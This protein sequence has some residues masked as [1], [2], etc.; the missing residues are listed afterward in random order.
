MSVRA[1]VTGGSGFIG[2][3]LVALF[4]E[5]GIPVVSL[6]ARPPRNSA[7]KTVWKALDI[8]DRP[9]LEGAIVDFDPTHVVH[10][11]ARTDLRE[12]T[13]IDGYRSNVLGVAN[14]IETL[15]GCATLEH[16]VFASSMLVCRNGYSPVSDTDYC[17][18]TLYGSSKVEG[19]RLIRGTGKTLPWTI[20]RPTSIWGPWFGEPY[21]NFFETVLAR[22]YF[23]PRGHAV[24]KALGF[25]GNTILQITG[26]LFADLERVRGRTFYLCD[27]PAYSVEQWANSI[28]RAAGLGAVR[29][30]PLWLFRLAASCGDAMQAVGIQN[31]P[32]TSF[33]LRNMLTQ[34][35]FD[36]EELAALAGG[37]PYSLDQGV[38]ATLHWLTE[39]QG[40]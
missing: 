13:N 39:S 11:A 35:R 31:P 28:H 38:S 2:T 32:L 12:T 27:S 20:V 40:N 23:H 33:R 10:L 36:G 15:Q 1:I 37:L 34:S 22:R 29:T 5:R 16:V 17:P 3:N 21:K 18:D 9:S 6:D 8:N 25:V 14:L 26:I 4:L 30:A 24:P 19:E 7:H